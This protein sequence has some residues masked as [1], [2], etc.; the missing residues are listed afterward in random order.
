MT[1]LGKD[2]SV[3]SKKNSS[4]WDK[5]DATTVLIAG[6]SCWL[7]F[8][9]S[10]IQYPFDWVWTF[11]SLGICLG[12]ITIQAMGIGHRL[13]TS[14]KRAGVAIAFNLVLAGLI[15]FVIKFWPL[16]GLTVL[17]VPLMRW[18]VKE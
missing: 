13:P 10:M 7:V 1:V 3:E 6:V 17:A 12:V 11:F 18:L 16:V 14:V 15:F 8:V 5:A 2:S 9:S 4:W